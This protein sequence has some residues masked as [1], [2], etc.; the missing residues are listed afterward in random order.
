VTTPSGAVFR[1]CPIAAGLT[2][3]AALPGALL[4]WDAGVRRTAAPTSTAQA[5]DPNDSRRIATG[6]CVYEAH[7]AACP[8]ANLEGQPDWRT[9]R[10]DG[11][12]PAPPHDDSGHARHHPF[13]VLFALTKHGVVPPY[14]PAN[15]HTDMPDFHDRL[16]D[17]EIWT[18]SRSFGAAGR[19]R[20][21]PP[22]TSCSVERRRNKASE[23]SAC[24]R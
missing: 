22:M 14:A 23:R 15:C 6:Q 12:L 21:G 20:Y 24:L 9:R 11:R 17:D 2:V 7:C 18:C 10:A 19:T 8:G 16:N 1:K 3:V 5:P 13:G 4:C